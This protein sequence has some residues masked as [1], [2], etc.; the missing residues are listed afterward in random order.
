VDAP[1]SVRGLAVEEFLKLSYVKVGSIVEQPD[2][3]VRVEFSIDLDPGQVAAK[4]WLVLDAAHQMALM[5]YCVGN[6]P[7]TSRVEF[8][9]GDLGGTMPVVVEMNSYEHWVRD[10][11]GSPL[12][13]TQTNHV[14]NFDFRAPPDKVFTLAAFGI[15]ERTGFQI[16]WYVW[17]FIASVVVLAIRGWFSWRSSKEDSGR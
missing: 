7:V 9:Y 1:Y 13:L 8:K 6:F 15:H 14:D 2:N 12:E 3:K 4:N 11:P 16:R 17:L 10:A 5:E